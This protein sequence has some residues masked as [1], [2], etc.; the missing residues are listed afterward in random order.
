MLPSGWACMAAST[1][2]SRASRCVFSQ[3][4]AREA[5]VLAAMRERPDGSA[6]D[7]VAIAYADTPRHLWP[8]AKRSLLAHVERIEAL[9]LARP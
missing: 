1:L 9:G 4:M 2:A 8:V 3:A 7:W 5:K 6:D